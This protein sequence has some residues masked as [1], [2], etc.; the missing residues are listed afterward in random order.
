MAE[1]LLHSG[2]EYFILDNAGR[3]A[4]HWAVIGGH[5]IV[6]AMLL[7]AGIDA[8]LRARDGRTA[9]D[10]ARDENIMLYAIMSAR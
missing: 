2:G 3:G 6:V 8:G 9:L 5:P 4:L 1:H 10:L 7:D